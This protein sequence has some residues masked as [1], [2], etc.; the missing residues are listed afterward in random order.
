M[1][2]LPP[3]T[4]WRTGRRL[5]IA[6]TVAALVLPLTQFGPTDVA[7][8]RT[9]SVGWLHT[10]GATILT[11]ANRPYTIKAAS[12]FGMETPTC[13]PH[14]MW[15]ITLDEGMARIASLGFNTVRLPYANECLRAPGTT[16]IDQTKNPSLAG[17]TP[18]QVMD[19]VIQRAEA[20]GLSVILD[21]H[22]PST[23]SQ[24]ELWYTRDYPESV[25]LADWQMLARRYKNS[26]TVIGVDL[27]NEP[28][29]PACWGCRDS[30]W[31]WAGAAR[32]AGNAVLAVNPRLLI[33]VQG[34]EKQG[35]G[36]RTWWGGGL[37][38]V[39]RRPL[40]LNVAHRVL[41]SPHEYPA[42]VYPQKWFSAPNYPRNL[43]RR[44]DQNWGYLDKKV[45]APVLVGEF[46][47][48][49]QT[50]SDQQWLDTLVGYLRSNK[51]SF[52]YWSFNP[53]SGDTGGLVKDDWRTPETAKIN[54]LKPI[55]R[56][57]R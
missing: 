5:A 36:E 16:S 50:R 45:I 40:R 53:N 10:S 41:Y 2:V 13:A 57:P 23:A 26:R 28:H 6:S 54:R 4:V 22:R 43:P 25:W 38:D 42:S 33:I 21:R 19:R 35:N 52:G 34:V 12:W 49:G 29:G 48:K 27:H 51:I 18:L 9:R 3:R 24:S 20:H 56:P 46:G 17:K 7:Q 15:T 47:T 32:R 14:G 31:D 1:S 37:S 44:W 8:A 11:S 39:G 55:L 30:A